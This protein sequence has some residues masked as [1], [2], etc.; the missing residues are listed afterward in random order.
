MIVGALGAI[1]VGW[2]PGA[3][4]F[5]IPWLDRDRRAA[6]PADERLFWAISS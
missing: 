1:I 3:V 6:L 5:R 2:L 4:F